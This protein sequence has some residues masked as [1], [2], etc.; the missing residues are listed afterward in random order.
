MR[1][2]RLLALLLGGSTIPREG[3][4]GRGQDAPIGDV[5]SSRLLYC[6]EAVLNIKNACDGGPVGAQAPPRQPGAHVMQCPRHR[7]GAL[8]AV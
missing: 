4:S 6:L 8:H 3:A 7:T 1:A 2:G 5:D